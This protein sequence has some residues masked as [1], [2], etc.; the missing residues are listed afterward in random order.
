[1]SNVTSAIIS[2]DLRYLSVLASTSHLDM[3]YALVILTIEHRTST[4][5]VNLNLFA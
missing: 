2:T 4:S 3:W 5:T 1:M